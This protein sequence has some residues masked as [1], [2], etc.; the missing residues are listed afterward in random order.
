MPAHSVFAQQAVAVHQMTA[1]VSVCCKTSSTR[2]YEFDTE[3][4]GNTKSDDSPSVTCHGYGNVCI[5]SRHDLEAVVPL[6]VKSCTL[7]LIPV[8][9]YATHVDVTKM[10][11]TLSY[12]P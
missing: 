4:V 12:L 11:K 9:V 10:A 3:Q 5:A 1:M 7:C 6:H 2:P 8:W